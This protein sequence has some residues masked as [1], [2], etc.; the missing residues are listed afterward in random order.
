MPSTN[1][2]AE[3]P[4]RPRYDPDPA[5]LCQR[6]KTVEVAPEIMVGHTN[7]KNQTSPLVVGVAHLNDHPFEINVEI[8]AT[9]LAVSTEN[10]STGLVVDAQGTE[11]IA[12]DENI[13]I[14]L[15]VD[16]GT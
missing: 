9:D 15:V 12:G 16:G 8:I 13:R 4:G 3:A 10:E 11:I 5:R 1:R 14:D 7:M 6:N 2:S